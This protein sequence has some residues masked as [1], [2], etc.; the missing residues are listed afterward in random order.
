LARERQE[1]EADLHSRLPALEL[2]LKELPTADRELIHQRYTIGCPVDE[3]VDRLG[4]SRRTLFRNLD[5]VRRL[6]FECIN[7]RL[8]TVTT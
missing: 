1:Q 2:C 5:R 6:L 7:R 8:Q 4:T 3:M